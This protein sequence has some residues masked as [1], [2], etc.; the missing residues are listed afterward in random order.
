MLELRVPIGIAA[1]LQGLALH[2]PTVVQQ[3]Q[4]FG[5]VPGRPT[6]PDSDAGSSKSFRP[7]PMVLRAIPGARAD[8]GFRRREEPAC[9]LVQAPANRSKPVANR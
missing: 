7:R 1:A 6:S 4:R 2:L 3:L 9:P 8:V 5:D